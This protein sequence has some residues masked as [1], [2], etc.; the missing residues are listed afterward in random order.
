MRLRR[1]HVKGDRKTVKARGAE[2]C[3][4][5]VSARNDREASN[6]TSVIWRLSKT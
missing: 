5:T 2:I 4:E 6:D 1:H 3:C